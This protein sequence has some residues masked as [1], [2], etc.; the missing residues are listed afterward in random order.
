MNFMFWTS[1]LIGHVPLFLQITVFNIMIG[2]KFPSNPK[3]VNLF[4]HISFPIHNMM[5]SSI[6]TEHPEFIQQ[7]VLI[8]IL[9][10]NTLSFKVCG[11]EELFL[12][13]CLHRKLMLA[14]SKLN[15][16]NGKEQYHSLYVRTE[17]N[18]LLSLLLHYSKNICSITTLMKWQL[19]TRAQ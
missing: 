11:E 8:N 9:F 12:C 3:G 16:S 6:R 5:H 2:I 18:H 13:V 15:T 4:F 10:R 17:L 19:G 1:K 14:P 7:E